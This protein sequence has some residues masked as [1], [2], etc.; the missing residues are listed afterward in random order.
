VT[1]A[2]IVAGY[3]RRVFSSWLAGWSWGLTL[4]ANQAVAPLIGL[5]IWTQAAPGRADVVTYFAALL[6]V[7]RFTPGY[8][9]H[10]FSGMIYDGTLT[11]VL[12]RPHSPVLGQV[13]WY[14]GVAAF[15][16]LFLA[17]VVLVLA[18]ALQVRPELIDVVQAMPSLLLAC[19]LAF[20]FDFSVACSAF[21]TQRYFAVADAAYR[22][23]FLFGGVAAPIPLLPANVRPWF[24]ALP[25]R[26]MRGYPAE[27]ASGLTDDVGRG[28]LIQAAWLVVLGSL[29]L[30]LYRRGVRRYTA[31]GG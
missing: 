3:G 12:L 20:A 2:V 28:L 10:T 26:W 13:G 5:A 30:V 27:I 25:F 24:D 15:D 19:G 21:W 8:G 16:L 6:I 17:P 31:I 14:F 22:L 18:L 23:L 7:T 4:F 11:D 29:A 1:S 9:V